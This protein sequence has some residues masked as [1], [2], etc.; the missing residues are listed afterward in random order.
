[1]D[2]TAQF[3]HGLR[4]A[5]GQ[6]PSHICAWRASL[7]HVSNRTAA[8]AAAPNTAPHQLRSSFIGSLFGMS[9]LESTSAIRRLRA[10]AQVPKVESPAQAAQRPL[11]VPISIL[12]L[13]CLSFGSRRSWAS[14]VDQ[15]VG[16]RGRHVTIGGSA[17][18]SPFVSKV[19]LA[20]MLIS[21]IR[22]FSE[23]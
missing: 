20:G 7:Q 2:P 12:H 4:Q 18:D 21:K 23:G 19:C 15:S 3:V 5:D 14:A 22:V 10:T 8:A 16:V 13:R 1:M 6:R 17:I 9:S 11:A